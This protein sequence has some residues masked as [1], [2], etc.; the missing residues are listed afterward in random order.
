MIYINAGRSSESKVSKKYGAN[1]SNQVQG[2]LKVNEGHK[3]MDL[4]YFMKNG[5]NMIKL[6]LFSTAILEYW[7]KILGLSFMLPYSER[8]KS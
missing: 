3:Y 2:H 8:S 4:V 6:H 1:F 7:R 5:Y